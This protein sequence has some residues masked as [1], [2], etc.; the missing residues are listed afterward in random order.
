MTRIVFCVWRHE[1]TPRVAV[2]RVRLRTVQRDSRRTHRLYGAEEDENV[3]K[4]RLRRSG[5]PEGSTAVSA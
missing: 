3:R 5:V 1:G 2:R 4:Q